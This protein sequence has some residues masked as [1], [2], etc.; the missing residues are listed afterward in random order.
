[1]E[2]LSQ[3]QQPLP[4]PR[5]WEDPG[6]GHQSKQKGDLLPLGVPTVAGPGFCQPL[7]PGLFCQL[8]VLGRWRSHT[9]RLPG[10]G[11]PEDRLLRP[12]GQR[13]SQHSRAGPRILPGTTRSC[14]SVQVSP[15]WI[16]RSAQ[17]PRPPPRKC[18]YEPGTSPRGARAWTADP[19]VQHDLTTEME[20]SHCLTYN[21][22]VQHSRPPLG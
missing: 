8:Q 9:S 2:A 11:R 1:M 6:L 21:T 20:I 12:R 5:S 14:H 3:N 16:L 13:R 18:T 19:R 15:E 4:A 10:K 22:K 7:L 17:H